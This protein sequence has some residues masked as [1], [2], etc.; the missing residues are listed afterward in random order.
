MNAFAALA[1]DTRRK[2]V[3]ML[4]N[5]GEL[6]ATEIS[7]NFDMTPPA[8]SQHLKVLREAKVIQMK[9]QA[10]KRLYSVDEAGINEIGDWLL[11]VKKIW[12]KRLDRLDNY[13]LKLKEEGNKNDK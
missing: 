10:Q 6:S 12:N 7:N 3:L 1:D 13:L 8:V 4:V 9:K 2:I 11:D 5:E